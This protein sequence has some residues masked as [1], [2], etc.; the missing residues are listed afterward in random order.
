MRTTIGQRQNGRYALDLLAAQR[1]LYQ[2]V[3]VLRRWRTALVGTGAALS[4]VVA[5]TLARDPVTVGVSTGATLLVINLTTSGLEKQRK[6]RAAALQE[7]FDTYVYRMPWNP[8]LADR[9]TSELVARYAGRH[10]ARFG[11]AGLTDWYP[12]ADATNRW[13]AVLLCQRTNVSW[14]APLH[15]RWAAL[16]AVVLGLLSTAV[17]MLGI[18]G[19]LAPATL[20]A[21]VVTPLL[22]PVQSLIESMR[23]NLEHARRGTRL[24]GE[25]QR[26][27]RASV[28]GSALP[29]EADCRHIQDQLFQL[30]TDGP[31]VPHLL[32]RIRRGPLHRIV[33]AQNTHLMSRAGGA[34]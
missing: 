11:D 28:E 9:P 14:D 6:A 32:Y 20:A 34:P 3:R 19:L 24:D 16:L 10:H 17:V 26:L 15:R 7:E 23:G 22:A 5:L 8:L 29:G 33:Q 30:R 4:C 27:W 25:I 1:A 13:T 2:Q 12:P 21:A 18:S 31:V